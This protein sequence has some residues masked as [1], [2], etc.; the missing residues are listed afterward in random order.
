MLIFLFFFFV[1]FL[2]NLVSQQPWWLNKSFLHFRQSLR[3]SQSTA[4]IIDPTRVVNVQRKGM[5][6]IHFIRLFIQFNYLLSMCFSREICRG[7]R[8]YQWKLQRGHAKNWGNF[9]MKFPMGGVN[10][11]K[12]KISRDTRAW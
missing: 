3:P 4:N 1:F 11:I 10:E 6:C 12:W 2:G 8:G 7:C 9:M 5:N